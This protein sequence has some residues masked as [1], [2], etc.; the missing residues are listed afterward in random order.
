MVCQVYKDKCK[1]QDNVF[2]K[3][4]FAKNEMGVGLLRKISALDRY[5]SYFYLLRLSGENC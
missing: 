3:R 2:L 5:Y 1:I 4:V